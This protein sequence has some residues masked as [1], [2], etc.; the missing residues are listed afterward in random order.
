MGK[1]SDVI[2]KWARML[3][4]FGLEWEGDEPERAD[5]VPFEALADIVQAKLRETAAKLWDAAT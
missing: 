4:E 5:T 1:R 2:E 3:Y